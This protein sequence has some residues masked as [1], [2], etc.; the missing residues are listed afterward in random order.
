MG[1]WPKH[2]NIQKWAQNPFKSGKCLNLNAIT[3]FLGECWAYK[4]GLRISVRASEVPFFGTQIWVPL[5]K[6]GT[7][8]M[9][10]WV[11]EQKIAG[12]MIDRLYAIKWP[13]EYREKLR[14]IKFG[15]IHHKY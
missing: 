6:M 13:L 1:K 7:K 10:L 3:S 14:Y 2:E 11:P 15:R 12:L 9:A 5:V 4:S 8:K